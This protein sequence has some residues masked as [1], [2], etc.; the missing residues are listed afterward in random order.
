MPKV[1]LKNIIKAFGPSLK[2]PFR[3]VLIH[4]KIILAG[5]IYLDATK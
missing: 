5:R 3:Y 1:P 2:I 4:N